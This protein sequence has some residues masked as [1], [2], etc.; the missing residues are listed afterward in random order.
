MREPSIR[1]YYD[2]FVDSVLNCFKAT[3]VIYI[4]VG[5]GTMF[6]AVMLMYIFPA[7]LYIAMPNVPLPHI[8]LAKLTAAQ[9]VGIACGFSF[10]FW[11]L[12]RKNRT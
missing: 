12:S 2:S 11:L 10:L 3:T 6:L 4:V 5:L 1:Y 9:W 7:Y 8:D